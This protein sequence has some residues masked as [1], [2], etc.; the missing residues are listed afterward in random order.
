MS[1]TADRDRDGI[2]A[3]EPDLDELAHEAG[4]AARRLSAAIAGATIVLLHGLV[5]WFTAALGLVAPLW[6]VTVLLVVWA[7]AGVLA[8]RWRARR[9]IVAMLVPLV[10][11]GVVLGAVALGSRLLGWSA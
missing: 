1:P 3:D 9:P 5:G 10:T 4:D 7:A 2:P 11:A 8:W 6:A